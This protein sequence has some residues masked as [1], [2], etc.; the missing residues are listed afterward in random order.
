MDLQVVVKL[1]KSTFFAGISSRDA[2]EPLIIIV[3]RFKEYTA[4]ISNK[5]IYIFTVLEEKSKPD[6]PLPSGWKL[7]CSGG[8][9]ALV[10]ETKGLEKAPIQ[11]A[12]AIISAIK[13]IEKGVV[14]IGN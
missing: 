3:G 7:E 6:F 4:Q 9:R 13:D 12:E 10:Y 8:K 2:G 11:V 14:N 1:I 5:G